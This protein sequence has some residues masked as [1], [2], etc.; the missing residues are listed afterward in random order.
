MEQLQCRRGEVGEKG[1]KN[2][3][4]RSTCNGRVPG[5]KENA[6]TRRKE[7]VRNGQQGGKGINNLNEKQKRY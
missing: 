6:G 4:N 1:V 3:K 7:R 5:D 2:R